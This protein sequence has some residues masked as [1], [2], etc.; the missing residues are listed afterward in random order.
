MPDEIPNT[1]AGKIVE[2]EEGIASAEFYYP[3]GQSQLTKREFTEFDKTTTIGDI[4]IIKFSPNALGEGFNFEIDQI[5]P[6]VKGD[7]SLAGA[8]K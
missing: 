7:F 6:P 4:V 1:V 5:V 3:D 2:I 8:G